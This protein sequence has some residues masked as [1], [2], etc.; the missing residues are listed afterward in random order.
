MREIEK[1][2]PNLPAQAKS[3]LNLVLAQMPQPDRPMVSLRTNMDDGILIRSYLNRSMKQDIAAI[4]VYNPLTVGMMAAMA[5]PAFQKVRTSSQEKAVMNN[6]RQLAAAADQYYLENGTT[7]ATY[8]QLVGPQKYIK[9]LNPV[10]GEN[11]RALR[12]QAGQPVRVR[13]QNGKTLQFPVN[14]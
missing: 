6:L 2:N 13:L 3:V 9:V 11:Y 4:S 5:I 12:F 8:D 1:L 14:R 10:A 7:T